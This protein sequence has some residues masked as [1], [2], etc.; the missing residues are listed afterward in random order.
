MLHSAGDKSLG[1]LFSDL[2]QK[3]STLVRQE[4]QLAKTELTQNV[5]RVA[6]SAVKLVIGG[7]LA[8]FGL[9]ALVAAVIL[10]LAQSMSPWLAALIVG[11]A[12][13]I[14]GGIVAMTGLSSMKKASLAPQ[15]TIDT[16]KEDAQWA[17]EHVTT[18]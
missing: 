15:N 12:I 7:V 3:F 2:T 13:I 18:H 14:I 10:L 4:V 1:E 11:I 9:Q 5:S 6:Q 8:L 16:L 17:K